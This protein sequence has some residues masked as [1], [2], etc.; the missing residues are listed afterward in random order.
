VSTKQNAILHAVTSTAI[1]VAVVLLIVTHTIAP[2]VGIPVLVGLG[3]VW[4]GVAGTLTL[5]APKT[6]PSGP[7]APAVV[8]SVPATPETPHAVAVAV[9]G[10]APLVVAEADQVAPTAPTALGAEHGAPLTS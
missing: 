3:G 4:S 2:D 1:G 9:P 5:S 8:A 7:V 6:A 10:I